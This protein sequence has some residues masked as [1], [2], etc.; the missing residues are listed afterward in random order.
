VAFRVIRP[1]YV[2][3]TILLPAIIWALLHLGDVSQFIS[4]GDLGNLANFETP[5]QSTFPATPGLLR[6]P[7]V[8]EGSDALLLGLVVLIAIA[9]VGFVRNI[10]S[11]PAWAFMISTSVGLILIAG[12]AYGNEGIFRA[13][14]FGIPWLAAVGTQALPRTRSRLPSFI[15]GVIAASLVG[16]YLV[17]SFSLDNFDVIRPADYQALLAYQATAS[18]DSYLLDLAHAGDVLPHS[19]DVPLAA[20]HSIDWATVITE[21]QAAITKPTIQ[22]ADTI[23]RQYYQYAKTTDGETGQLYAIWSPAAANYGVDYGLETLA[24]AQGWRAAIIA[25]PDWK[26]VYANDGT[27]LFRVTPDVFSSK[28]TVKRASKS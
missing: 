28:K 23:A 4:V 2:P 24:Q 18:P 10:R 8:G 26:V 16:V 7:A 5:Q 17:S 21:G 6:L 14:L 15:Y 27:Y 9:G 11:R 20:T 22:D 3:V 25:S 12:N 13:A 19:V 1:W